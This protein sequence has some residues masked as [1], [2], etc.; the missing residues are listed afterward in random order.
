MS[1]FSTMLG[2][3]RAN[4]LESGARYAKVTTTTAGATDGT[5]IFSANLVEND[6]AWNRCDCTILSGASA[7]LIGTT[8]KVEDFQ[9]TTNKLFF[10]NNPFVAQV[11]NGATIELTEPAVWTGQDLKKYIEQAANWFL[12]QAND[13]NANYAV[14]ETIA[15]TAGLVNLPANILKFMEPFV[16]VSNIPVTIIEPDEADWFND[17]YRNSNSQYIGYFLGRASSSTAIGR[18]RYHPTNNVNFVFN[19]V[20]RASFDVNGTWSVP[21]EAWDMIAMLATGIALIANESQNLA[22]NWLQLAVAH[23]PKQKD[24]LKAFGQLRTRA[25]V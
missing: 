14:Q 7:I 20:P 8:K 13:L 19:F 2:L 9:A 25:E 10:T 22:A 6:D 3:V 24:L 18:L 15:G 4:L 23:L 16:S 11:P 17:P 12:R 5:T 21:E 1:D